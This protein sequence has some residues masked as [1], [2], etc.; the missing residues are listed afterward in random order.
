MGAHFVRD[1][2]CIIDTENLTWREVSAE[3]SGEMMP[4]SGLSATV[5]DT[6]IFVIG[7]HHDFTVQNNV[8]LLKTE[9][10]IERKE[11]FPHTSLLNDMAFLWDNRQFC[12]LTLVV[13][14]QEVQVH[15][16]LLWVRCPYFRSMFSSGMTETKKDRIVI[17]GVPMR[18]FTYILEFIYSAH[19]TPLISP[20]YDVEAV[21]NVLI[22]ANEFMIEDLVALCENKLIDTLDCSNV[23]SLLEL[24]TFYFA[25]TLRSACVNYISNNYDALSKSMD[26]DELPSETKDE[27][28]R[29]KA[30]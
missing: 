12:D 24:A 18:Y 10:P 7:G 29:L 20:D 9:R 23:I 8:F 5:M 30:L 19:C 11:V 4:R 3:C 13:E 17:E 25:T 27:I 16:T 15:R 14:G 26:F 2:I 28:K 6:K 22:L 1:D 21:K